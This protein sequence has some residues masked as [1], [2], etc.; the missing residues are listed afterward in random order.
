M[1]A[2]VQD[3]MDIGMEYTLTVDGTVVDSTE[4]KDAFHY[5]HGRRQ[6]IP[7]LER[8]LIG[9]HAGDAAEV[10]VAPEEGYGPLDPT[11][12]I[13]IPKTQLPSDVAPEL[14]IV[15][16]GVNPD[17]ESFRARIS[18]LKGENVVLDLNHPL[19]GK[20]LTFKVTILDITPVLPQ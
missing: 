3:N 19:A 14:G 10:T 11:A 15:L 8:Q 6:V 4:G 7:G 5:I 1:A 18:E 2:A 13:E 16:R 9:L 20:T 17:G 12:L